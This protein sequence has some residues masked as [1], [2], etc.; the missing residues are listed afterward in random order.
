M[1][2]KVSMKRITLVHQVL[3]A[4]VHLSFYCVKVR[5]HDFLAGV[6]KL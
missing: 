2:Y 3:L 4:V 5:L 1:G 6:V